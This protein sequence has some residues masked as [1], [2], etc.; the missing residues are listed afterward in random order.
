MKFKMALVLAAM[1]AISA[2]GV[3]LATTR[4]SHSS[5][6]AAVVTVHV[7]DEYTPYEKLIFKNANS[8][9]N[10]LASTISLNFI[11]HSLRPFDA[12][13]SNRASHFFKI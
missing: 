5:Q 7:P 10:P 1:L 6:D 4:A 8:L 3:G 13:T 2:A 12:K 9:E 11:S